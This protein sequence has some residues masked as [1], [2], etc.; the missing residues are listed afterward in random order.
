MYWFDSVHNWLE[1]VGNFA[2]DTFQMHE[3]NVQLV[4]QENQYLKGS[5]RRLR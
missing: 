5:G 1:R 4:F 2:M 3:H